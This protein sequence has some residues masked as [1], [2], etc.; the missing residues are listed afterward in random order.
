MARHLNGSNKLIVVFTGIGT[1]FWL[2]LMLLH[3]FLKRLNTHIIYL[4]DL[5]QFFFLDGLESVARGY[6]GLLQ[7]LRGAVRELGAEEVYVLAN[8]A[9]GFAGL[10]YAIDLRA[11][12]FLGLSIP[13]DL[14]GS[15]PVGEFLTRDS[16]RQVA[17]RCSWTLG[18]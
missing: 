12:S 5:R 13:T 16:V 3:L 18:P 8:S 10:R 15:L 11:N 6:Q 7:A 14:S 2:S 9:G 4:S 1:R 17:L